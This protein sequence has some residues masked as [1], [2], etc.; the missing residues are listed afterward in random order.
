MPFAFSAFLGIDDVHV[1]LQRN[2]GVRALK[3]AGATYGALRGD[4]LVGHFRSPELSSKELRPASIKP[5]AIP[6][7]IVRYGFFPLSGATDG[8]CIRD[9]LSDL[10]QSIR[11]RSENR[12]REKCRSRPV[13]HLL[14]QAG[15]GVNGR[16]SDYREPRGSTVVKS[17]RASTEPAPSAQ[18]AS[19]V[20]AR[21]ALR[22]C[23]RL[24][25]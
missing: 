10:L 2:R 22:S 3:F 12:R 1:A 23:S 8:C 20:N 24:R 11:S 14:R 16:F 19:C 15:F 7:N 4:D 9:S 5:R 17:D 18:L 25:G 6:Q 21:M 13:D